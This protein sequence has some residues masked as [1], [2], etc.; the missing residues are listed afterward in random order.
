LIAALKRIN[1]FSDDAVASGFPAVA[2][3]AM[4]ENQ[5]LQ[6]RRRID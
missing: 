2:P 6:H 5:K 1:R 3:E 4:Q